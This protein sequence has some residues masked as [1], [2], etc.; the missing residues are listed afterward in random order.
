MA[1]A[2]AA[3]H[4]LELDEDLTFH[5]VG[6]SGYRGRNAKA[7]RL[8]VFMEAVEAGQVPQGS[9]LLVEQ[10]DRISRMEP[11][12]ALDVLRDIL[13]SGV[14][15]V[16]LNDGRQYTQ[17][18][19]NKNWADLLMA[20]LVFV[21]ANEESAAKSLRG[22]AFWSTKRTKATERPLTAMTPEWVH[23]NKETGKL[24]LI[25][26]RAEVVRRVFEMTLKGVGVQKIAETF[27]REGLETWG[28][29]KRKSTAWHRSYILRLVQNPAVLGAFTM[30]R[31]DYQDGKAIRVP[32][33]T[34]SDYFPKVIDAETFEEANVA[35]IAR[36]D[37]V[38]VPRVRF[39]TQNILAG[40]ALC[41]K[42][43]GGMVRVMKG[44]RTY[45]AFAC[46]AAKSRRGCEYRSV[47]YQQIESRLLQVLPT[48]LRDRDGLH[49]GA[50]ELEAQLS[51]AELAFVDLSERVELMVEDLQSERDQ[52]VR[53]LLR[54]RLSSLAAARNAAEEEL[55]ALRVRRERL[56][57]AVVQRRIDAVIALLQV[58]QDGE[59][60]RAAVNHA[61][62]TIFSTA[63]INHPEG[64][65]DLEWRAGGT[66]RVHYA[67]VAPVPYQSG[68]YL[69]APEE[70]RD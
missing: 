34:I 33:Q 6:V 1:Q 16:T 18:S 3:Q 56:A 37:Q 69:Y 70:G 54:E 15:V 40:M 10:L 68:D 50:E 67:M 53:A 11:L 57:G 61:L 9:V 52:G 44:S 46:S 7:G 47:R 58:S 65:V 63:V 31:T 19:L 62:R 20:V 45:P 35:R 42:C 59:L 8:A 60:D 14:S 12:N 28:R 66:L 5:D 26:D 13:K 41:P 27:N 64:A 43:G 22:N 24:E 38:R 48:A 17:D 39:P 49:G 25:A 55:K 29:G 51:N 30:H 2:Y 21:R 23:L 36:A 4:G 32:V